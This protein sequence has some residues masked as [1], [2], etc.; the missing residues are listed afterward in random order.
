MNSVHRIGTRDWAHLEY[1]TPTVGRALHN[2]VLVG[3][4][5]GHALIFTFNS[6]LAEFHASSA[7]SARRWQQSPPKP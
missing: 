4:Y 2:I 3:V 6:A 5:D 7:L 1:T